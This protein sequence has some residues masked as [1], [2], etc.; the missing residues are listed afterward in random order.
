[1]LMGILYLVGLAVV[2]YL[3]GGEWQDPP[4]DGCE[5]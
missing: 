5:L 1:M 2:V 3:F 4:D